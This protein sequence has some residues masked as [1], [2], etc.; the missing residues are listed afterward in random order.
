MN[1]N[2]IILVITLVIA[3]VGALVLGESVASENY[4]VVVAIVGAIIMVGVIATLKSNIWVLIPIFFAF[5]GK[6]LLLPLPF[7]VSNLAVMFV[8]TVIV[9]QMALGWIKPRFKITKTDVFGLFC[10]ASVGLTFLL[11]PVGL[12]AMNSDT[13]GARPYFEIALGL[14]AYLVLAS[15][16]PNLKVLRKLPIMQISLSLFMTIGSAL[17]YFFVSIG[18]RLYIVYT[19][20]APHLASSANPNKIE[21][22]RLRFLTP[23][24]KMWMLYTMARPNAWKIGALG[25]GLTLTA[26]ALH[27]GAA[28]MSGHRLALINWV[29]HIGLF[30]LITR[31]FKLGFIAVF[32]GMTAIGGLYT[33]HHV[34]GPIPLSAQRALTVIPGD[35]DH[36]VIRETEESTDWRI[37]MWEQALFR[38][39]MINNKVI[40]DG[41]SYSSQELEVLK[42]MQTGEGSMGGISPED[43][44]QYYLVTGDLHSGPVSTI[45]HIGYVGLFFVVIF[46]I[47]VAVGYYRLC[48]RNREKPMWIVFMF[49]GIPGI[50]FP[51]SYIFLY[52]DFKSQFPFLL[53][54]AGMMKLLQ[55]AELLQNKQ[56]QYEQEAMQSQKNSDLSRLA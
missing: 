14:C 30:I 15:I 45:K 35:W 6:I 17:S 34:I 42:L 32:F 37:D 46:A 27:L 25:V 40:G 2:I 18:S 43:L 20:F 5:G 1:N 49:F 44:A 47:A 29:A 33:Y 16:T 51:I 8:F 21:V 53:V 56:L 24:A 52:G 10:L 9:A 4:A 41:F 28:L 39:G 48:M 26:I 11:N 3:F 50:M 22:A 7:S 55:K 23:P 12:S 38:R 54:S 36:H 19:G 13:V 31:N